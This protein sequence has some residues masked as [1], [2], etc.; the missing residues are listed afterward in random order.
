[1]SERDE[2]ELVK[3]SQK[4]VDLDISL[5]TSHLT[6]VILC[7]NLLINF[8]EC[9][10]GIPG[11]EHLN[12]SS[13]Q[14]KEIPLTISNLKSLKWLNL[15][16]NAIQSI[17]STFGNLMQLFHLDLTFNELTDDSFPKQFF[18]LPNL[19]RL[20][21]SDNL[22]QTL[23]S[24]ITSLSTLQTLALRNNKLDRVTKDLKD[25]EFLSEIHLQANE[26]RFLPPEFADCLELGGNES[27]IKL[28]GNPW[29]LPIKDQ[30]RLGSSHVLTYIQSKTYKIVYDRHHKPRE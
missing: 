22:I 19:K 25:L 1:M 11:L 7:H 28:E 24:S 17:P 27:A 30:L 6:K 8:P 26:L 15:S 3:I 21:L 29:I 12:L 13:N 4:I 9:L 23:G 18:T 5:V 14:I 16:L 2:P 10:L 20:Y